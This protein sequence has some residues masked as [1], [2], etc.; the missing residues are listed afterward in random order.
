MKQQQKSGWSF[1]CGSAIVL[2]AI[3]AFCLV[4]WLWY[5]SSQE[6]ARVPATWTLNAPAGRSHGLWTED[7]LTSED[8]CPG[9]LL[10]ELL[11]GTKLRP[12]WRGCLTSTWDASYRYC[13]VQVLSGDLEGQYGWVNEDFIRKW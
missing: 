6:R 8:S 2:L 7:A 11:S 13:H 10:G 1:G 4:G 5:R 9:C 12:A 3:L